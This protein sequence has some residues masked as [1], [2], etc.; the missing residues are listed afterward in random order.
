MVDLFSEV[1][2]D[3]LFASIHQQS[4]QLEGLSNQALS[5]GIDRYTEKDYEGAAIE[6]QR[7]INLSPN[8]TYAADATK[9]L[10]Q[11]LLKL[12]KTDEA[13]EAYQNTLQRHTDNDGLYIELGNLFFA[14]NRF[15]EAVKAYQSAANITPS[16]NN[17]YSLGQGL[18]K[19]SQYG[20]AKEAFKSVIRLDPR[21]PEAYTSLGKVYAEE[22][23]YDRAFEQ[24]E[25]AISKQ[26]DY[27][28]A[29]AEMGYVYA[30]M[31]E[32]D[33]AKEMVD[34]LEYKD[35][36]LHALLYEYVNQAEKPRISFAWASSTFRYNMTFQTPVAA[37]DAYL[38][39]A[40]ASKS[41]YVEFQFSKA[42]D[43][44]SVENIANW[45][46]SRAAGT[47][48][49]DTYNFGEPIPDSEIALDS[50]PDYVLY[51]AENMT[52][53]VSFTVRQNSTADGTI[54]PSHIVFKFSGKDAQGND[55]NEDYDEFCGFSK[56]A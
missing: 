38:E 19:T 45:S 4:Y 34:F 15:E 55:M 10:A 39:N 36:T 21:S 46:I 9:Y 33:K 28:D 25:I 42:M 41:L 52:A 7:S 27:Y 5:N 18:L 30:D 1:T 6:F 24:Y 2:A 43:R 44:S 53:T 12:G 54:D 22:G 47:G 26:G 49:V 48:P 3:D 32:M 35:D 23:D 50:I 20:L 13:I 17:L 56:S 14:E 8:S 51:D 29:Y 16:A 11:S 40:D 37:M 31:E